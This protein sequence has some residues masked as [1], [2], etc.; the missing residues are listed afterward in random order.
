MYSGHKPHHGM[1]FQS[2]ETPG[3]LF[4][5]MF[6]AINGNR[7]DSHMMTQSGLLQKLHNLT[8]AGNEQDGGEDHIVVC[9]QTLQ[10]HNQHIFLVDIDIQPLDPVKP[11]GTHSC[12]VFANLLN[13]DLP[14]S[15]GTGRF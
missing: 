1:K 9:M 8:P 6:G 7:H 5:C 10:T 12:Q 2:I 14:T 3:G 13:G 15:T 4:A 11:C